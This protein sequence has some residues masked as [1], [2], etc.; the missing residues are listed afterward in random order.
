MLR[1]LKHENVRIVFL[2][3][4]AAA[5]TINRFEQKCYFYGILV[6]KD[7]TGAE[8]SKAIGKTVCKVA[9]VIDYGFYNAIYRQLNGG[10]K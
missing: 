3:N 6:N 4:D 1:A 7:F 10:I 8:L 5:N 2:A 9:A